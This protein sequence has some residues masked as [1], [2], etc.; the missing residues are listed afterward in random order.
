MTLSACSHAQHHAR[1]VSGTAIAA[2]TRQPGD[3]RRRQG[4]EGC[5]R[6]DD[7]ACKQEERRR[8]LAGWDSTHDE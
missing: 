1:L 5:M 4:R 8:G 7:E 3:E 2:L 6:R